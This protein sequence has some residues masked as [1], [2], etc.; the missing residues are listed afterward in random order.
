MSDSKE[1]EAEIKINKPH[2][3][4]SGWWWV[5]AGLG[6]ASITLAVMAIFP[7][8]SVRLAQLPDSILIE[9]IPKSSYHSPDGTWWGYNQSK[10]ARY[11]E[12]VFMYI[13]DNQDDN[14]S[15]VSQMVIYQKDGDGP[16]RKGAGF[17]TSR[18]GN[19][20]IDSK[21]VLHAFVFEPLDIE[22]NDSFGKLMHY[23][24]PDASSDNI[25]DYKS[26]T[27]IANDGSYEHVNIRVGAAIAPDDTLAVGFGLTENNPPG[28]GH[29]EHLYIKNP[30]DRE[31][32]HMVAGTNLGHD[33]Y[34]PFIV[35]TDDGFY[36]LT[37]QDDYYEPDPSR[38]NIYQKI[39]YLEYRGGQWQQDT[40]ADLTGHP[41][42]Q[43]RLRLLE[44][45]ELWVDDTDQTHITYKEFTHP[46]DDW[47][48]NRLVH[49]QGGIGAWTETVIEEEGID[50]VRLFEAN[51][52]LYYLLAGYNQL[53]IQAV[54][55]IDELIVDL[56]RDARGFY[57]YIGTRKTGQVSNNYLDV[58]VHASDPNH[59]ESAASYYV[60]VPTSALPN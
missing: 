40:I 2:R 45:S 17:P 27:A 33:F 41:L 34:Y 38:Y 46:R 36:M 18:P 31:W 29:S 23:W 26:E 3:L 60:R 58:I 49:L 30:G 39:L 16:W 11:G 21:G 24:F 48:A 1:T 22:K 59:Y 44:Q 19:I 55:G 28:A 35:A 32:I 25:T 4:L 43:D 15:T 57:P 50:W 54:E 56:P 37:V 6:V 42:A 14:R 20:L 12:R 13:I 8:R 47:R 9:A 53:V 7:P 5:L 52:R 10:L 51:G